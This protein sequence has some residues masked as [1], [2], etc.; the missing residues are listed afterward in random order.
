MTPSLRI[1]FEHELSSARG[2]RRAGAL[3]RAMHH[4][5]RA[6]VLGQ[7]WVGP[8]VRSH[9]AML[10]VGIARRDAREVLGQLLRIPAGALGS[11]VGV[12]P[13]GNTGGA[14]VGAFRP[15][16]VPEDLARQLAAARAEESR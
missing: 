7:A 14:N 9:V 10:R 6:H 13:T 16:P 8:H 15:M 11:A 3:D 12:V 2:A 1:A 4:L 5:E